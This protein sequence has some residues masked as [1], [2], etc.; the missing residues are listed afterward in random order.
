L[1][2]VDPAL[3][4]EVQ[5]DGDQLAINVTAQS[6]AHFV[7]LKLAGIDVVFSDNY[8]SIPAGRTIRVTCPLPAG[9]SLAQAKNALQLYS[10]YDSFA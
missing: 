6:L 2:L 8:F 7:E 1:S 9:W 3:S 10:L 5:R 4:T